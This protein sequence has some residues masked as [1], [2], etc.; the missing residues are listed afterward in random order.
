[1]LSSDHRVELGYRLGVFETQCDNPYR[2]SERREPRVAV[3]LGDYVAVFVVVLTLGPPL[4]RALR[5][6]VAGA[7]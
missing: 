7:P 5:D 2:A 1:M 4:K 6:A 3:D